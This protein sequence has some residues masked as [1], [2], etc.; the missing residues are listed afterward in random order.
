MECKQELCE[1]WTGDGRVCMCV[2]LDLKEKEMDHEHW[3][4]N[5]FDPSGYQRVPAVRVRWLY[6]KGYHDGPLD[7]RVLV[8]GAELWAEVFEEC[9]ELDEESQCS[10]SRKYVLYH[11]EQDCDAEEKRRQALF[12]EH[13]GVYWS[14]N[15]DGSR[16]DG[17]L[18]PDSEW[19]KFYDQQK[20]WPKWEPKG[21]I[22]GWFQI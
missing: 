3:N 20:T 5:N 4:S 16:K 6:I 14:F 9:T 19:H 17:Q 21:T 18:K 7:G 11:L 22:V 12:E 2:L 10:F 8:G 1:Y 13:V 15:P